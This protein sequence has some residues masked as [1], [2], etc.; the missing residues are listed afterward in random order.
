MSLTG[1]A[2]H[3][4]IGASGFAWKRVLTLEQT[5]NEFKEFR[6]LRCGIASSVGLF[7]TAP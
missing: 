4:L 5:E 1:R 6:G 3:D 2:D 7:Q